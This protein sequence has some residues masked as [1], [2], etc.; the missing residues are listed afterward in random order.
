M[1]LHNIILTTYPAQFY[2]DVPLYCYHTIVYMSLLC[3]HKYVIII[4]FKHMPGR[5]AWYLLNIGAVR[6]EFA[7]M[8]ELMKVAEEPQ[9]IGEW[10][11]DDI[12]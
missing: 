8:E 7:P 4:H 12:I 3:F 10:R 6:I 5:C 1:I 9:T 2:L 11:T